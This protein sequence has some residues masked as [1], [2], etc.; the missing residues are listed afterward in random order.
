MPTGVYARVCRS[1]KERL[2]E[3]LAYP[4]GLGGHWLFTGTHNGSGH[5]FIRA[6]PGTEPLQLLAHRAAYMV[7]V[8]PIP[9]GLQ[10]LHHCVP[11]AD[12]PAC[13]NPAHLKLGTHAENMHDASL[14]GQAL[15]GELSPVAKLT[16]DDVQVLRRLRRDGW[17]QQELA[18]A[19]HISNGHV[20]LL[21]R[22]LAWHHLPS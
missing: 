9:E 22:G 18:E 17:K 14:K 15:R 16:A 3:K 12:D 1:L 7:Y 10:V 11:Y 8:G 5:G 21:V 4:D 6:E 13:C 20:S 2:E 19:F